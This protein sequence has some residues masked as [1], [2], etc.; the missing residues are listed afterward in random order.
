MQMTA[1]TAL[2]LPN[3]PPS[4]AVP[5]PAGAAGEPLGPRGG[6]YRNIWRYAAGAKLM[7]IASSMLLFGSQLIKLAVPWLAAQAINAL[8]QNHRH[9]ILHAAGYI[10]LVVLTF[11]AAWAMHGPGRIMERAVGIRIRQA[12]ADAL[13]AKLMR[14][15][16]SWH[17]RNHSADVQQ[18]MGQ[19]TGALYGFAQNQFVYL[20]SAVNLVG[21]LV[22]LCLFSR[23]LGA[24]ALVGYVLVGFA[25]LRFDRPLM[26]L[27]VEENVAERRYQAGLM[28]FLGNVSTVLSLRLQENTRRLLGERIA[29]IFVPLKRSITLNEVKWC[30][31][32]LF[33]V[34]LTW[35]LVA[36]FVW[37]SGH[38]AGGVVLIGSVF[39]V[40]QYAQQ[41]SGVIGSIAGNFQG[42]AR[43]RT[44]FASA[45]PI[46]ATADRPGAGTAIPADWKRIEISDLC[47][48]HPAA[49]A[50]TDP[51]HG[52]TAEEVAQA[53]AGLHHVALTLERGDRIALVGSSGSGKSTLMRVLAGLYSPKQRA[54]TVDSV[55]QPGA[56]HLGS[57]STLIPQEADVFEATVR[58]NVAFG[59]AATD[60][61]VMAA[62][63]TSAFDAVLADM[64]QGLNTP[65]TERGFNLSGG[66]RQRLCLA[67]GVLAAQSSSL[68][69]L[70]EP[71]SALDPVTEEAVFNR[72]SSFFADACLVASVHRMS[73]L[74]HFNKVVLMA[75]GR[76]IDSGTVEELLERQPSF[77]QMT[78][79]QPQHPPALELVASL[80]PP[81]RPHR[82][83]HPHP[84]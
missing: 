48:E 76:V 81:L 18:R 7:L 66:Q 34:A 41:A 64:A 49:V 54:I 50:I 60:D 71:T 26:K 47:Y 68:V 57:I 3:L 53:P 15:P 10:A 45:E 55:A 58:E 13:Y 62:A 30:A 19:S 84:R 12:H 11:V 1:V 72:M 51:D 33:S 83:P 27:A 22:A 44:D 28:D 43:T 70:D 29:M 75:D 20:Q 17:D 35:G 37:L 46:W 67:R 8:Q 14:L 40:Y 80:G 21:P 63:H 16:M 5:A 69:M 52:S 4:A 2:L 79:L 59:G 82:H 9:S 24:M 31:V 42:F 78:G 32:D 61:A 23:S 74:H 77:R 36:T 65:I 56:R 6:L 39:M 25:I 73:L 38:H